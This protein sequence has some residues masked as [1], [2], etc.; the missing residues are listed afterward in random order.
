MGTEDNVFFIHLHQTQIDRNTQGMKP[1]AEYQ[2]KKALSSMRNSGGG[3]LFVHHCKSISRPV[4]DVF[5]ST[6]VPVLGTM[7]NDDEIMSDGFRWHHLE[8]EGGRVYKIDVLPSETFITVDMKTKLV[9]WCANRQVCASF[10][11]L[12]PLLL[13]SRKVPKTE[14]TIQGLP[15][16]SQANAVKVYVGR[17]DDTLFYHSIVAS[18][19]SVSAWVDHIFTSSLPEYV[20]SISKRKQGGSVYVG[21]TSNDNKVDMDG[22]P[23]PKQGRKH[24]MQ[25]MLEEELQKKICVFKNKYSDIALKPKDVFQI[26]I[27]DTG[28]NSGIIEV[29]VRPVN[30]C[31]FTDAL[32][33]ASFRVE[34]KSMGQNH[35]QAFVRL[36]FD[37]WMEMASG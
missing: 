36:P 3:A 32:G 1:S 26:R 33:P 12:K 22:I 21:R 4:K 25:S 35:Y 27:H 9:A 19:F 34:N 8:S 24:E 23:F 5:Q 6:V 18:F 14:P 31:V 7:L 15:H 37:E 30:G 11:K 2:F 28:T 29:A 17:T 10:D 16:M 20:T 13:S